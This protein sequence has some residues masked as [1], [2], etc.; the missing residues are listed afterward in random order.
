MVVAIHGLGDRPESFAA[1]VGT[2]GVPARIIL[3]RGLDAYEGG[4]SWFPFTSRGRDMDELARGIG[5]AADRLAAAL[6]ELQRTRPTRGLPIVT[7][8]SQGG[9]LTYALAVRH[10]DVVGAAFPLSGMLPP[11]LWPTAKGAGRYPNIVAYHGDADR[12][13]PVFAARET[14]ARL[15]ELG[16]TAELRESPG[17][18]HTVPPEVRRELGALIEAAA[19]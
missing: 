15:K 8:F 16:F 1:A 6:A 12:L 7:G 18:G 4:W 14:V 19:R 13:V 5:G 9:M 10:P 2:I 3:P 11:P 17:V